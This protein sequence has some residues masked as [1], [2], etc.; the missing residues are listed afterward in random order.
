[1][2][3]SGV[4]VERDRHAAFHSYGLAAAQDHVRAMNLLG[5]CYEQGWGVP[6]DLGLA[7]AWYRRSAEGGYF[8]GAFN[9]ADM[10]AA[11]GCI[12]RALHWFERALASAP[13]P[14]RRNMITALSSHREP[15][16]RALGNRWDR[17]LRPPAGH[18]ARDKSIE[19]RHQE[20]AD[21]QAA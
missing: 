7:R 4:G 6:R 15:V 2:L 11:E 20:D 9:Y 5:R 21:Q 16:L 17:P 18:P 8:R 14:T 1:M 10:I 12:A 13:E 3:L 19:R